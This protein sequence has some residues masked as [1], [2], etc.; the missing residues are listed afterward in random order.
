MI[1]RLGFWNRLALVAAVA[2]SLIYPTYWLVQEN[3]KS[4]KITNIGYDACMKNRYYR[5]YE[6]KTQFDHCWQLWKVDMKPTYPNA[7]D[8]GIMVTATATLSVIL[9]LLTFG[10]VWI[11]KWIWRGRAAKA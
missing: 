3:A 5:P 4:A 2:F 11:A 1:K 10:V 9:Y 8:W 6:G 7:D